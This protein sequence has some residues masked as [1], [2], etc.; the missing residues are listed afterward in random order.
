MADYYNLLLPVRHRCFGNLP[1][2]CIL[3][4]I[5][6]RR[7]SDGARCRTMSRGTRR[8]DRAWLDLSVVK[9]LESALLRLTPHDV[10]LPTANGM[11]F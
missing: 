6:E 11:R 2:C 1:V 4:A 3:P 8:S 7:S 9:P 10:A 5:F